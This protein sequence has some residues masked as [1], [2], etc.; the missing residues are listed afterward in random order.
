MWSTGEEAV[1]GTSAPVLERTKESETVAWSHRASARSAM[2]TWSPSTGVQM[3]D[4]WRLPKALERQGFCEP[5]PP[6]EELTVRSHRRW[7]GRAGR[8]EAHLPS[9]IFFRFARPLV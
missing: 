7:P 4:T 8:P 1:S 2:T 9:T 5:R 3:V 6:L